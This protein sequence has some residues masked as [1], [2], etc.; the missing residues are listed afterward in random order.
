VQSL[1]Q[2]ERKEKDLLLTWGNSSRQHHC[3]IEATSHCHGL[4]CWVCS[5]EFE[6]WPASIAIA[7]TVNPA[8]AIKVMTYVT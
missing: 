1:T 8:G 2:T 7:F 5:L 6:V 4:V 3:Y